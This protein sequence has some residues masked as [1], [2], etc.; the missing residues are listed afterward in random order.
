M[1]LEIIPAP[2]E[3]RLAGELKYT[4]WQHENSILRVRENSGSSRSEIVLPT[5]RIK[6][7]FINRW[8]NLG[9]RDE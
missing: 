5:E 4:K 3:I 9:L 7:V 8:Q 1:K 6:E 2:K